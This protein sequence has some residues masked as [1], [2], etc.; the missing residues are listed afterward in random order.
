MY[1][2]FFGKFYLFKNKTIY[3][4]FVF[5]YDFYIEELYFCLKMSLKVDKK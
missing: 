5:H 1:Q 3:F 4:K 2:H